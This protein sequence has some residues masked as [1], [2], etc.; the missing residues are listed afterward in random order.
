MIYNPCPDLTLIIVFHDIS[1]RLNEWQGSETLR[2]HGGVMFERYISPRRYFLAS[3]AS[4]SC[5]TSFYLFF[6]LLT[7]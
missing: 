4:V 2:A 6:S 5:F 1:R 7:T 3:R